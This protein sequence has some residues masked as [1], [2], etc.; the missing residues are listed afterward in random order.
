MTFNMNK[1]KLNLMPRIQ[2]ILSSW[3]FGICHARKMLIKIAFQSH[4]SVRR[5]VQYLHG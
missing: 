5:E 2:F 1:D 4:D 3:F